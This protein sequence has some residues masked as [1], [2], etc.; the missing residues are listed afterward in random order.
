VRR[1]AGRTTLSDRLL[2]S[3]RS[4]LIS[5]TTARSAAACA[6]SKQHREP[7]PSNPPQ[8]N[9]PTPQTDG[10]LLHEGPPQHRRL[11]RRRR[12]PRP[13]SRPRL[14]PRPRPRHHLD[15]REPQPGRGQRGRGAGV[16][17]LTQG[18][19]RLGGEGGVPG[20]WGSG[21]GGLT[22]P[23]WRGS[24]Y[25]NLTPSSSTPLSLSQACTHLARPAQPR[26]TALLSRAPRHHHDRWAS[27]AAA[28]TP[29]GSASA[30]AT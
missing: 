6:C 21:V 28:S 11:C 18:A 8:P 4:G 7:P 29:P 10:H 30:R 20:C 2:R 26:A 12:R 17:H 27:S 25:F 15:Q 13:R 22:A 23:F 19:A 3:G 16:R 24:T 14:R 5:S 9:Q 1:R